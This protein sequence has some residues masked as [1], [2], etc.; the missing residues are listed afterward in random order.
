LNYNTSSL[1]LEKGPLLMLGYCLVGHYLD[2]Q[3]GS[4]RSR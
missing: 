1:C 2:G 4:R 3:C